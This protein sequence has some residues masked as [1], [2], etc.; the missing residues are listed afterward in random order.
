MRAAGEDV[1]SFAAGEPDF[2]TPMPAIEA[3]DRAM[4][5]G[6]TRYTPS[7]GTPDLRSAIVDKLSRDN[8]LTYRPE[9]IV[10]SCGA[11]QSCYNTFQVL[12]DPGDEVILIAPYWMTYKEQIELA[13]GRAVV[14]KTRAE[15]GFLPDPEALSAAV[16]PKTR[17]ILVNSPS[18]PTGAV[19]PRAV[20]EHVAELALRHDLWIVSDEIYE[21]LVYGDAE[22]PSIAGFSDDVKAR[23]VT[24]DGMSKAF[25]MTGWRIGYAAAPVAV[26]KAMGALQ[27]Q[28]TSNPT[29]FAQVGAAA[30]LRMGP[31]T[32][33]G[34]RKEFET[35][36]D[37]IVGLFRAIPKL[38]VP[39]PRGAF[40]L[41]PDFSAY[42][43]GDDV[44]LAAH[45]LEAARVAVIPG[46]V[47]EGPGCLRL[48][49][50]CGRPQIE[51]G[52][53]RIAAA[54]SELDS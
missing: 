24:I 38:G 50:A 28:V 19:L 2:E 15:D 40:Y 27:D 29:S 42:M 51:A 14:V 30:A 16:G 20:L 22:A 5:S 18:N 23:T 47:F 9:E 49:Y 26:A 8:G 48:S 41:F 46:S 12:L 52:A 43:G 32:V 7:V 1:L 11:K 25:A 13:G 54:L 17:A 6:V 45:L 33:E 53:A 44:A 36:R 10:V 31:E 3:A 21:R 4:R 34:M 39:E 35:R 37:L